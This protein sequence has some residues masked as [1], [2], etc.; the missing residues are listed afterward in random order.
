MEAVL[1]DRCEARL[2]LIQ[3]L[4]MQSACEQASVTRIHAELLQGKLL[5]CAWNWHMTH[6]GHGCVFWGSTG[7]AMNSA[8]L[9]TWPSNE[10]NKA[11]L[12]CAVSSL[13]NA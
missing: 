13:S 2:S 4:R 10:S 5:H 1:Y 12:P 11:E 8:L 9:A 7:I 6:M 3:H